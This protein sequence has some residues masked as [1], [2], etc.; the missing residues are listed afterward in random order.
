MTERKRKSHF[1]RQLEAKRDAA[2]QQPAPEEMSE[3]EAEAPP[4]RVLRERPP[5]LWPAKKRRAPWK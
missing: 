4:S 3:P 2:R 5:L 1:L